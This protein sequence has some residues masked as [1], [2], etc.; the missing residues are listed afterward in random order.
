MLSSHTVPSCW[1]QG[2]QNQHVFLLRAEWFEVASSDYLEASHSFQVHVA[3]TRSAVGE[4]EG[5][6]VPMV[7]LVLRN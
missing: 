3:W 6:L 1:N 2:L 7:T 4:V 5:S